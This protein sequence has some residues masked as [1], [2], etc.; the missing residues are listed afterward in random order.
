M[1]EQCLG[2][3]RAAETVS[4]ELLGLVNL[5][6]VDCLGANFSPC[7]VRGVLICG[8]PRSG[9]TA[10]A[11]ALEQLGF[12]LGSASDAPV[13][14][15]AALHPPL[16]AALGGELRQKAA[17]LQELERQLDALASGSDRY[18]IKL[19]DYYRVLNQ[20]PCPRGIDL[21]LFVTRDPICVALRNSKSVGM[22]RDSAISRALKQYAEL[23][24]VATA[25]ETPSLLVSYEKLI[26]MPADLLRALAQILGVSPGEERLEQ[27]VSAVVL[28]DQ[29][30]LQSSS[31]QFGDLR[32]EIGF[33]GNGRIGGWC[34]WSGMPEKRVSLEVRTESGEVVGAGSTRRLRAELVDMGVHPTGEVGF[35]IEL[36][37]PVP[38]TELSFVA[39]GR[40]VALSPSAKL[41]QRLRRAAE[42]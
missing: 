22:N 39:D 19:P 21:I 5:G 36:S 41:R 3:G 13:A 15:I 28:N 1:K 29:R 37:R 6:I 8:L 33:F 34:F 31:L 16:K 11:R 24:E 27:A 23:I 38:L 32:G 17:L 12:S 14:E 42:T 7:E 9:T 10:F 35:R 20:Q 4:E 40:A 30:Y 25:C 18:A 26:A 2:G